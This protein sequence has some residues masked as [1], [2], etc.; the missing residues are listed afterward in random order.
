MPRSGR[1]LVAVANLLHGS[2]QLVT[3]ESIQQWTRELSKLNVRRTTTSHKALKVEEE[4]IQLVEDLGYFE[5][6]F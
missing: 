2:G 6:T 1:D 5:E 3:T 4:F